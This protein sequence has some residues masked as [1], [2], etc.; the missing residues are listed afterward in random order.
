MKL[1]LSDS[2]YYDSINLANKCLNELNNKSVPLE[3][4][5]ASY[6]ELLIK[7]MAQSQ[8]DAI[9]KNE[10][11]ENLFPD[12][13]VMTTDLELMVRDIRQLIRAEINKEF[14]CSSNQD[15]VK[16]II[17]NYINTHPSNS[18]ERP[19]TFEQIQSFSMRGV[20]KTSLQNLS[21]KYKFE[22]TINYFKCNALLDV[23]MGVSV[24]TFV[25]NY[26]GENLESFL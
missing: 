4:C 18:R 22:V 7:V 6:N 24:K 14:N 5:I 2:Y 19:V 16:M 13:S 12:L 26:L 11:N 8:S 25:E 20:I 23:K 3:S 10:K 21:Y 1:L 17:R 9:R 15:V